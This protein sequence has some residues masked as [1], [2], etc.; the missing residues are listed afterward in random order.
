MQ[1]KVAVPSSL[2]SWFVFHFL[3]DY[4]FA[5]PLFFIPVQILTF[6][7]WISID[8]F[9]VRLLAAALLAIGGISFFT[10]NASLPVYRA[11]LLLKIIWSFSAILGILITLPQG[12]PLSGWII[13]LLFLLFSSVWIYYYK[14]LS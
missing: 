9:T 3:V 4:F 13:L 14:R 8:P 11:I 1:K 10:R 12:V 6:L 2:R 5:I 7:G